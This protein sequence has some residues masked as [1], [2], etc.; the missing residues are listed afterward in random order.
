M[1]VKVMMFMDGSWFYHSRQTLF[2]GAE[3]ESFEID[4]NRMRTLVA[5]TLDKALDQ[6]IDI[7]RTCYFGTLPLNKIG[8]NPAK[9]RAFYS[10]LGTH[11]GF[12]AEITE[13]DLRQEPAG[14]DDRGVGVSLA[15]R[16]MQLA[17]IPG[18]FD[19]A[20]LI[21]GS[22]EYP[23]LL[24]GLRALGKRTMLVT[25][26]NRVGCD[27][28]TSPSLLETSG[29][30][31]FPVLYLDDHLPEIKLVRTEQVRTCKQC[32]ATEAT[33]WAGPEFF[34]SKCREDHRR[35][36]RVCDTCGRE[37]ETTWDKEYFYCS[38]CRR[39]HRE[40]KAREEAFSAAAPAPAPAAAA[41][42]ETP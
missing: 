16:A 12:D 4:Y 10:F 13:I 1:S 33:T 30:L 34:C 40:R 36:V 37:E 7:A 31:D 21:G 22:R 14:T 25:I 2:S 19:L 35:R 17:A 9:Q 5:E 6:E 32:G 20:V 8:Y 39:L 38:E 42:T 18:A 27:A 41:E 11:C 26:R 28:V 23:A 15:V 29:I 3:E 24:R